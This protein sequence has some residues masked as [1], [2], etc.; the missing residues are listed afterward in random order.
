ME[1]DPAGNGPVH[2]LNPSAMAERQTLNGCAAHSLIS[3]LI[4]LTLGTVKENV[5][6]WKGSLFGGAIKEGFP[7]EKTVLSPLIQ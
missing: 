4:M 7:E 2:C 3:W 5:L 1:R 6:C